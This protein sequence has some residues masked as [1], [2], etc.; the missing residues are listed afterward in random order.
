M[1]QSKKHNAQYPFV[2]GNPALWRGDPTKKGA[3]FR[4]VV[5]TSD[6]WMLTEGKF[7]V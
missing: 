5:I 2:R 1:E 4:Q 7:Q 3:Q 6:Q